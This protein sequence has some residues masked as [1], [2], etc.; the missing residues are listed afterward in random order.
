MSRLK[1]VDD[2]WILRRLER[3][4]KSSNMPF[5]G[6]DKAKIVQRIMK[7]RKP[8]VVVEVGGMCGYS[9]LRMAQALPQ[10]ADASHPGVR[11]APALP[12]GANGRTLAA[13]VQLC[14]CCAAIRSVTRGGAV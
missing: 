5:L 2:D 10:G 8:Q 4:G 3:W 9:A 7:E 13:N 6:P 1:D 11:M 12:R 14:T